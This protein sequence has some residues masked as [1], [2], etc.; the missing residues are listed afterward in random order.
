[1]IDS[2]VM[3]VVRLTEVFRQAANSRIIT[4]AHRINQGLMP[5]LPEPDAASDFYFVQRQ[6]ADAILRSLL[7]V[8]SRRI[9]SK[10]SLD[11]I[12]DIQVLTPMNR[13]SLGVSELN[14]RLQAALNPPRPGEAAIEKF[15]SRFSVRDKVIQTENNYD[16]DV[17]N[18]DIG[19]VSA[20]NPDERELTVRFDQREV[21]YDFGELDELALAY[22]ITIHKSQG[23]EFPAV[24][25]PLAAQHYLLL[26][27]NLVYTAVTRGKRLVLLIG[28]PKAL[29]MA[30]ANNRTQRRY[31]G[32]LFRL[33]AAG[34]A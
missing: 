28:Q 4:S 25:V 11:P 5:E 29:A 15:G 18:G 2:G 13:G 3:P 24:V 30:V 9:P 32:L 12:A 22:A 27:R 1:L 14:Q 34:Q 8:V 33:R 26:Q 20:L 16:K 17:F 6:D 31:S 21:A 10:F 19:Q 23:S 7:E